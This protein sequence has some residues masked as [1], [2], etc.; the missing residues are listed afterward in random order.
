M[1]RL[2]FVLLLI[3]GFLILINPNIHA[4]PYNLPAYPS[5]Y[6]GYPVP[7]GRIWENQSFKSWPFQWPR[8]YQYA[9]QPLPPVYNPSLKTGRLQ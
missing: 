2:I 7:Y 4:Q 6:T 1:K 3:S 8:G 9:Y 5:F